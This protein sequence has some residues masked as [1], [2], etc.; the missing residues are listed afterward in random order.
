[1][2]CDWDLLLDEE[3][4][5]NITYAMIW[6]WSFENCISLY[7]LFE[8]GLRENHF[9]NGLNALVYYRTMLEMPRRY[10]SS[11]GKAILAIRKMVWSLQW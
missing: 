4:D 2:W 10:G 3:Y 6:E 7:K 11:W 9:V 5:E 1:M 8:L